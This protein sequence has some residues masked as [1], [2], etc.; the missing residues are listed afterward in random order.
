MSVSGFSKE[1]HGNFLTGAWKGIPKFKRSKKNSYVEGSCRR[2]TVRRKT[3]LHLN[4]GKCYCILNGKIQEVIKN[5]V[6]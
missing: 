5:Y 1:K 2:L 4:N 6:F 3:V